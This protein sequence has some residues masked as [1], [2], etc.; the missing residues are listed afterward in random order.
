MA[1]TIACVR[2]VGTVSLTLVWIH[3]ASGKDSV[4]LY[5]QRTQ[6]LAAQ[7]FERWQQGASATQNAGGPIQIKSS[8]GTKASAAAHQ[9]ALREYLSKLVPEMK[10]SSNV[11]H[12]PREYP[13]LVDVQNPNKNWTKFYS[14]A[15]NSLR[16]NVAYEWNSNAGQYRAMVTLTE[17]HIATLKDN[18]DILMW[19]RNELDIKANGSNH[20]GAKQF[21][22]FLDHFVANLL[23][24]LP[25]APKIDL[26]TG[27]VAGDQWK[28]DE[29]NL[30]E[31]LIM[32]YRYLVAKHQVYEEYDQFGPADRELL[33]SMMKI[34]FLVG[35]HMNPDW[36]QEMDVNL[37]QIT[38][39]TKWKQPIVDALEVLKEE[40][41]D[42]A[43]YEQPCVIAIPPPKPK[44]VVPPK[45][46]E[47]VEEQ[48]VEI[49]IRSKP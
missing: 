31:Q 25:S 21:K 33:I 41:T 24:G 20:Q 40:E 35:A 23:E 26:T 10:P 27:K 13:V 37:K 48:K 19:Y 36:F 39:D 49:I 15:K 30:R 9:A 2:F 8:G 1:S 7:S 22:L 28:L 46:K 14:K 45:P 18:F 29:Q 34:A 11:A 43:D 38:K 16:P 12:I 42:T 3:A 32:A 44:A 17:D 4:N 47:V 5:T 6:A